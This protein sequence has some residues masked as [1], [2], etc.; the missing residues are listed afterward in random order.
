M[1]QINILGTAYNV[2]YNFESAELD[3]ICRHYD[4][5]IGVRPVDKMLDAEDGQAAKTI[6]QKET[7]RHEIMHA[8]FN[9]CGLSDY[10]NDERLVD[11]IAMQLPRII[12][13]CK[14]ADAL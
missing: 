8:F 3:G 1:R 2:D 5:Y 4:K 9:E 12:D 14:A 6:R 10:T 11:W 7:L 13:T